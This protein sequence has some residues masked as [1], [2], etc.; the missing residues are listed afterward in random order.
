MGFLGQTELDIICPKLLATH[1]A[2]K[3]AVLLES[4]LV[5]QM[6]RHCDALSRSRSTFLFHAATHDTVQENDKSVAFQEFRSQMWV[7]LID[8][9]SVLPFSGTRR[10]GS[11]VL[12]RSAD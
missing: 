8:L 11:L 6:S 12:Q 3:E 5:V 7:R 9:W 2:N 10:S 1:S 4:A